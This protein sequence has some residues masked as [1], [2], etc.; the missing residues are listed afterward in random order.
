MINRV[1][2]LVFVLLLAALLPSASAEISFTTSPVWTS[3][4]LRCST[5]GVVADFDRDGFLD[6]AVSNGND[7]AIEPEVIY[8]GN[9]TG[10]ATD[11][12]WISTDEDYSGHCI[13]GDLNGDL[14]PELIVGN[15]ISSPTGFTPSIV[16][17]YGNHDGVLTDAPVW[18]SADLNN[19]FSVALG[20]VD[21]DGDL[22]LACANGE[23]YTQK[24][25][26][27][28]IYLNE[29]G[30]LSVNP[31]WVSDDEDCSYDLEFADFDRDGDLDLAVANSR[32]PTR[33]YT[34]TGTTLE[35]A[36]SWSSSI[37]DNDNSIT[38]ADVD[39][40]GWLDL[41]VITNS[42]I[43][44]ST[45]KI[46][47]FMNRF[48][49]IETSPSWSVFSPGTQPYGSAIVFRDFDSDLDLDLAAGSWWSQ[50]VVYENNGHSL[51]VEPVIVSE[52]AF[53]IE[54]I[55]VWTSSD[56]R[57]LDE[58]TVRIDE[59][60]SVV[61]LTGIPPE[62]IRDVHLNGDLLQADQ[63]CIDPGCQWISFARALEPG[64]E[65]RIVVE[66]GSDLELLVTSWGDSGAQGPNYGY[67]NSSTTPP[68]ER[69]IE[70]KANQAIFE[71]GD[72]F[73]LAAT[74]H[75]PMESFSADL[76]ILME[77]EGLFF[78][79]PQWTQD[80]Q[81]VPVQIAQYDRLHLPVL[82]FTFGPSIGYDGMIRFY[83][84]IFYPGTF[85]L[86]GP[87]HS[88]ELRLSEGN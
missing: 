59:P 85:D 3:G 81:S 65:L 66:R 58:K 46:K 10:V 74:I 13:A 1:S 28:D 6:F 83:G 51:E 25:Q 2:L 57:I 38:W 4:D 23:S 61:T 62:M 71:G 60:A 82:D 19:T 35:T 22:D 87:Y 48:G 54:Q 49:T 78:F 70:L 14:F 30:D 31:D 77:V 27:N 32:A 75:N 15:Y 86:A 76:Y 63:Y 68:L 50:V 53:V 43:N 45:G 21:G 8:W 80:L 73:H 40:D 44:P 47:I 26:P 12:G 7:M 9:A 67:R 24:P 16:K 20:D 64:D 5:G 11:P 37:I 29:G 88:I 84:A 34:N 33:I 52:N 36:A 69:S 55:A 39:G 17:Q 72:T 42:Q 56:G 79:Y 41:A 18:S